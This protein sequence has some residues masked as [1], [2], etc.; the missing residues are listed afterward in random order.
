LWSLH[1]C[2][3]VRVKNAAIICI[4]KES[5]LKYLNAPPESAHHPPSVL[6]WILKDVDNGLWLAAMQKQGDN[7]EY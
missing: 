2:R 1:I 6:C 7:P 3:R 4:S 5:S